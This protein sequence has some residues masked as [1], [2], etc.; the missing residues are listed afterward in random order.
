M[1]FRNYMNAKHMFH[2]ESDTSKSPCR[3]YCTFESL[4]NYLLFFLMFW[5]P[6][7]K[8]FSAHGMFVIVNDF[9][10]TSLRGLWG[11]GNWIEDVEV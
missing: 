4:P 2:H 1:W 11:E 5:P 10:M 8:G 7:L 3:L 9:L 6:D